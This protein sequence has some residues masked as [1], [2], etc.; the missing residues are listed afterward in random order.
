MSSY[1]FQCMY[2]TGYDTSIFL[3]SIQIELII[4]LCVKPWGFGIVRWTIYSATPAKTILG[5]L[6]IM[7]AHFLDLKDLVLMFNG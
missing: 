5:L 6:G 2:C 7:V 3:Q 4:F 1:Y